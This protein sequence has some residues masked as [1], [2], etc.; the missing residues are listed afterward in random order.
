[1]VASR[2][3]APIT[4]DI[5]DWAD[6]DQLFDVAAELVTSYDGEIYVLP[7]MLN[8][9]QIYCRRDILEENGIST[10][11]PGSWAELLD[12]AREIREVT[13]S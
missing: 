9:Q 11:Q 12:R 7:Q 6:Y 3:L 1:M 8:V 2:Y 10:E 4:S 13:G 5:Q